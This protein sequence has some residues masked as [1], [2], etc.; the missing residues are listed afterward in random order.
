MGKHSHSNRGGK[1]YDLIDRLKHENQKLKRE[2]KTARKML[3]RYLVA[4]E[5]GLIE[6]G[7][8][9][10]SQKREKEAELVEQWTCYEC[11]KGVLRLIRIGNRYFRKC[12]HCDKHTKSQLWDPSVKGVPAIKR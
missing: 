5:K 4:E 10:P 7:V 3:D 2:L 9:V 8:I 11:G 12:S 1:E 6:E